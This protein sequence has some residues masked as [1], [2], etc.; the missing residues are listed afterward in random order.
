MQ[1]ETKAIQIYFKLHQQNE[2]VKSKQKYTHALT[3]S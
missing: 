2:D 1:F 3:F